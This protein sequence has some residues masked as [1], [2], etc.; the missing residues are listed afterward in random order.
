[1]LHFR[2]EAS[3]SVGARMNVMRFTVVDRDGAVSF[4]LHGDALPAF[5]ASCS[6]DPANLESL[7]DRADPYYSGLKDY[8]SSGL[9]VFDEHN[10]AANP[11]AIHQAFGFL[12]PQDQPVFRVVDERT[13]EESLRP[14]KAGV[15]IFNLI[16]KRIV[17]LQ[18]TYY[19][20]ARKGR[21]RV[22]DG[23]RLTDRVFVY[24]LPER[25][26]LVP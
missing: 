10:T 6:S 11:S 19:A 23:V 2:T 7:L 14:V 24:R 1:M 26:A 13:R 3:V 15:V 4:I 16:A 8:V 9:A 5:L 17:Q 12:A 25:W 21:G 18:N 22:Y 20:I